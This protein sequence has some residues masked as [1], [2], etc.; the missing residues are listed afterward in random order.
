MHAAAVFPSWLGGITGC[1]VGRCCPPRMPKVTAVPAASTLAR[2]VSLK[3]RPWED[4]LGTAVSVA[5]T[6]QSRVNLLRGSTNSAARPFGCRDVGSEAD[7]RDFADF[8]CSGH[9][10]DTAAGTRLN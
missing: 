5:F 8:S 1:L 4:D 10:P 6:P 7:V 9:K 2:G 3:C